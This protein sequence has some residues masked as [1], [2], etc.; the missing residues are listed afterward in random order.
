MNKVLIM[1]RLT[2]E[3][4]LKFSQ[5]NVSFCKFTVAVKRNYKNTT[6]GEYEADFIPC[7][8]WKNKAEFI[9]KYF[10]KGQMIAL[11]GSL[12]TG[13]YKDRKFP[14]ITHYTTDLFVE[15]AEFAGSKNTEKASDFDEIILTDEPLPF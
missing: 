12:R 1:G 11:E 14:E 2:A 13:S 10:H 5:N 9:V 4:E 6:N 7:T 3:P 15:N 8:A